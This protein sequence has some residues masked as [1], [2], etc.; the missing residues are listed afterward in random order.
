MDNGVQV[1]DGDVTA[2]ITEDMTFGAV[3]E[4][5]TETKYD[6]NGEEV[7]F[8]QKMVSHS[9]QP[10]SWFVNGV[11]AD[12][13]TE[14]TFYVFG[15][16]NITKSDEAA[17]A[18]PTVSILGSAEKDGMFAT[19]ARVYNPTGANILSLGTRFTSATVYDRLNGAQWDDATFKSVFADFEENKSNYVADAFI[20]NT[21]T[22][23]YMTILSPVEE[24]KKRVAKAFIET[25]DGFVFS[26]VCG[27]SAA[28]Q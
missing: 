5:D 21:T 22:K 6:V 19:F 16:M 26:D 27:N 12:Y 15:E 4:L 18:E 11:F 25:E 10:V 23:D 17:P 3:Y 9:E 2:L 28:M 8:D 1:W 13:G 20:T 24:G 7:C 14:F